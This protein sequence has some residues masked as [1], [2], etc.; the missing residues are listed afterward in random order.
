MYLQVSMLINLLQTINIEDIGSM[1]GTYLNNYQLKTKEAR[2]LIDGDVLVFGTEV[3][4]G[5]EPFP[6]CAFR[7]AYEFFPYR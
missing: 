3:K 4:R 2:G 5:E 6:A 7:V 1:H